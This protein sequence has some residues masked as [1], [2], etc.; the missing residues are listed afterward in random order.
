[1]SITPPKLRRE[2]LR[3]ALPGTVAMLNG[4]G[5]DFIPQG[6]LDDY[7]ALS[8]LEDRGAGLQLTYSGAALCMDIAA[9]AH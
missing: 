8:W 1:M 6:F 2:Q 4:G 3:D 9:G 7:V 5:V